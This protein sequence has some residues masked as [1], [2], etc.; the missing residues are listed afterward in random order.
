MIVQCKDD[1]SLFE[2][3]DMGATWTKAIGTLSGVRTNSRLGVF[4]EDN[5]PVEAPITATIEGVK[6]MLYTWKRNFSG[7]KKENVFHLWVTDNNRTFSVGSVAM[8]NN[9]ELFHTLLYSDGA[10][11]IL[12]DGIIK[13]SNTISLVPL[14]EGLQMINYVLKSWAQ[15][16]SSFSE[17]FTPTAGLVGFLSNALS[18]GDTWIDDY[19]CVNA[20]VTKNAMKAK[21]GF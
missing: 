13:E 7:D 6:V 20:I 15:L 17:L 11:H 12:Q 8:D 4:R 9:L 10:L 18:G 14:T 3:R 2:S 21:D 1:Q 16:D 19:L 5:L